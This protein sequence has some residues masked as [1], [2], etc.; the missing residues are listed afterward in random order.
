MPP[1]PPPA[2][3]FYG[4]KPPSIFVQPPMLKLT[5]TPENNKSNE[6]KNIL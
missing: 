3:P 6:K 2:L 5:E 1:N 4:L